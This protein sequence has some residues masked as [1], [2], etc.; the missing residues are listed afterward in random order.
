MIVNWLQMSRSTTTIAAAALM[1]FATPALAETSWIMASG[2]PEDSFFTKNIRLFIED[3]KEATGGELVI[4][5]R[6]ND[7]LIKHDAIKRAVQVGQV[8]AG[9]IRL[10]VYGN[11]NIVYG[12]PSVAM[13]YDSRMLGGNSSLTADLLPRVAAAV[14]VVSWRVLTEDPHRIVTP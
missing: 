6:S 8:Q 14:E 1:A 4:D 9:E 5:L 7:S 10:S 2:Y 3:V 12:T 13:N 11:E